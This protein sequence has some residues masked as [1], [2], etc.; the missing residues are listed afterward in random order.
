MVS[1]QTGRQLV[2]LVDNVESLAAATGRADLAER[3]E[4]TRKR[5]QDP[6]VRVIVVGEFKKGKSKLIN[7]L[8]NAPVCP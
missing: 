1:P 5:L 8:V 7:A 6:N 2:A 4:N 3:L